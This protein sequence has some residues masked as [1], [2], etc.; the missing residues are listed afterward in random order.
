MLCAAQMDTL[1]AGSRFGFDTGVRMSIVLLKSCMR[2]DVSSRHIVQH[3]F[4]SYLQNMTT[5]MFETFMFFSARRVSR[6]IN[7]NARSSLHIATIGIVR[8]V[9]FYQMLSRSMASVTFKF[10]I[11]VGP[12]VSP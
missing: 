4:E 6:N 8:G 2:H 12:S 10:R 1:S 5:H 11:D 9:S 7:S 3:D